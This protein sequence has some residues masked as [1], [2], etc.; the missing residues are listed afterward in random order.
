VSSRHSWRTRRSVFPDSC[1]SLAASR[2]RGGSARGAEADRGNACRGAR[3]NDPSG[4]LVPQ[5]VIGDQAN[6]EWLGPQ[7]LRGK[8]K[9]FAE[10]GQVRDG[11]F[12]ELEDLQVS[13]V[14]G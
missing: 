8:V 1:G 10:R 11:R 9:S 3:G 2:Q 4:R 12:A 5:L 6:S 13:Q 14:V 7:Q